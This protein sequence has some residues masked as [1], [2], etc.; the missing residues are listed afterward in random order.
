MTAGRATARAAAGRAG[1][2]AAAAELRRL[3]MRILDRN[4]RCDRLELDI[5]ADDG[6]VVVFAEVRTRA[7]SGPAAPAETI[8]P[9]KRRHL[10]DA[11]LLWLAEHESWD[12][13]CRFDVI[14]VLHRDGTFSAEHLPNAFDLSD[15]GTSLDRG[16][17]AWQ[18]W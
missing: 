15:A 18:P 9:S 1:E 14:S 11:A 4:W 6:G 3:G 5:V 10:R 17:A 13:P 7:A 16:D 8:S 2:D 12:R